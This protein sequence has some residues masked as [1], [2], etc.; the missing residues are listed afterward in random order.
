MPRLAAQTNAEFAQIENLFGG[1]GPAMLVSA[2]EMNAQFGMV[3][4]GVP[5]P[6]RS[7]HVATPAVFAR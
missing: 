1:G 5:T 4:P 3:A 7:A 6:S 2:P